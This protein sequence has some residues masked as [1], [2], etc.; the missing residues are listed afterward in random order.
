[1]SSTETSLATALNQVYPIFEPN[2]LLTSTHLNQLRNY[3]DIQDRLSR[4]KLVGIGI[5]CG[6]EVS[7]SDNTITISKGTGVTSEG[8]L[9]HMEEESFTLSSEDGYADPKNYP[10]FIDEGDSITGQ[11]P[12]WELLPSDTEVDPVIDFSLPEFSD[13]LNDKVVVL[14]MEYKDIDLENCVGDNCDDKGQRRQLTIRRLL[15]QCTEVDRIIREGYDIP[16]D[17]APNNSLDGSLNIRFQPDY[18]VMRAFSLIPE[19]TAPEAFESKYQEYTTAESIRNRYEDLYPDSDANSLKNLSTKIVDA[20]NYYEPWLSG[21]I[22][23]SGINTLSDTFDD[24][25]SDYSATGMI[26]YYYDYSKDIVKAYNEFIEIAFEITAECCPGEEIFPRHLVLGKVKEGV[27]CPEN[28]SD[29]KPKVYRT[30][31]IQSPIYNQQK[32][33]LKQAQ[34]YFVRLVDMI[35]SMRSTFLV[36]D[37]LKIT[38]SNEKQAELGKR[39]IPFYYE[40]DPL[41]LNWNFELSKRCIAN[42]NLGYSMSDVSSFDFNNEPLKFNMDPYNFY[43][44]EGLLGKTYLEAC[45]Q[46]AILKH[47]HHLDFDI[48]P[49]KLR[50]N[51][52]EELETIAAEIETSG[53]TNWCDE[54]KSCFTTDIREE[55]L[56]LRNEIIAETEKYN[57]ILIKLIYLMANSKEIMDGLSENEATGTIVATDSI[58]SATDA[59]DLLDEVAV[60]IAALPKCVDDFDMDAF[61][62]AFKDVQEMSFIVSALFENFLRS[63]YNANAIYGA[64]FA[65]IFQNILERFL[66]VNYGYIGSIYDLNDILRSHL[67]VQMQSVYFSYLQR[68]DSIENSRLFSNFAKNNPG[69]EHMAGVPKGGTFIMVYGEGVDSPSVVADFALAGKVCCEPKFPFCKENVEPYPPTAKS[70]YYFIEFDF[71]QGTSFNIDVLEFAF[72][73]NVEDIDIV[74]FPAGSKSKKNGDIVRIDSPTLERAVVKYTPS[75]DFNGGIDKFEYTIKN[76]PSGKSDT[77]CVF[78]AR[79]TASKNMLLDAFTRFDNLPNNSSGASSGGTGSTGDGNDDVTNSGL[80]DI[81]MRNPSWHNHM[82]RIAITEIHGS[83]VNEE[84]NIAGFMIDRTKD[85]YKRI[86]DLGSKKEGASSRE[87]KEYEKRV[88]KE[89]RGVMKETSDSIRAIDLQLGEEPAT[90]KEKLMYRLEFEDQLAKRDALV[91]LYENQSKTLA[92]IVDSEG[93]ATDE[94]SEMFKFLDKEVRKQHGI[95]G[96]HTRVVERNF[97]EIGKRE[98]INASTSVLLASFRTNR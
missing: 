29:C 45:K 10:F 84:G 64:L 16:Y 37:T 93:L 15:L 50:K 28:E 26:Q 35:N 53:E 90:M 4:V 1:M 12:M 96:K 31:F 67:D 44:I 27:G 72:D 86:K 20:Y 61:K 32:D 5:V 30:H 92:E 63:F 34:S 60:L 36:S 55:Y 46:L 40:V 43:R 71:E 82:D 59:F 19:G 48:L 79:V 38:P 49:I 66:L 65:P 56:Q 75:N 88:I 14:F 11:I 22:S 52:Q 77:A 7:F 70:V 9:I 69:L 25:L 78:V 89:I 41:Y 17:R 73:L 87:S 83:R 18:E 33:K 23:V 81:T 85:T 6:L 94:R 62:A 80:G 13:F 97:S 95:V 47:Q 57:W 8:F 24:L 68:L 58:D 51:S 21:I 42:R 76:R 74:D 2:Q 39:S 98:S 3:L 91:S 54:N